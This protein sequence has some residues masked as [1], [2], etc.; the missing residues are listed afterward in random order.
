MTDPDTIHAWVQAAPFRAHV[1]HLLDTTGLPWPVVALE[2]GV[3]PA[4]VHH[5]LF[6]RRGRRMTRIPPQSAVALLRLDAVSLLGTAARWVPAGPTAARVADLLSRGLQA[7]TLAR[8]CR[9]TES[10]LEALREMPRCTRL[11]ALLVEAI[12]LIHARSAERM[13]AAA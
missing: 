3:P 8:H 6:G 5:L 10:E 4:L 9:L 2:A 12:Q 7:S 11:T 1:R 13:P